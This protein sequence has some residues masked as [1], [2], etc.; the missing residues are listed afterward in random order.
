MFN[1]D[2][3]ECLAELPEDVRFILLLCSLV[4]NDSKI[5]LLTKR[6]QSLEN[7]FASMRLLFSNFEK[8]IKK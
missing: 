8:N 3:E 6:V 2:L 4:N 7:N 1:K 5:N